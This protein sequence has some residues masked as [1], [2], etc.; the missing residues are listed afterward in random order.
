MGPWS[1]KMLGSVLIAPL[2][3][4]IGRYVLFPHFLLP[5]LFSMLC[6]YYHLDAVS[7]VTT[8]MLYLLLSFGCFGKSDLTPLFSIARD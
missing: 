1:A 8:W 6:Q 5:A 2:S 3:F 7:V 4:A